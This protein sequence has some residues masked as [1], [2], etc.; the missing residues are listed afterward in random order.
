[1]PFNMSVAGRYTLRFALNGTIIKNCVY[2]K[3]KICSIFCIIKKLTNAR[4]VYLLITVDF[5]KF[6]TCLIV[7]S[8]SFLMIF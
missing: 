8:F 4:Q 3:N 2:L 6:S 7:P 5:L 1:M